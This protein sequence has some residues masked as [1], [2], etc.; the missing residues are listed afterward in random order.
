M[1]YVRAYGIE[2]ELRQPANGACIRHIIS[3]VKKFSLKIGVVSSGVGSKR[4]QTG[5]HGYL[6]DH[7]LKS[8][9]RAIESIG[10]SN[11]E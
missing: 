9:R 3:E 8:V 5:P 1:K 2:I 10:D 11:S 4:L 7:S 6:D